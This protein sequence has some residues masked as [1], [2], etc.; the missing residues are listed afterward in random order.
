MNS[1]IEIALWSSHKLY[2]D[3]D[4]HLMGPYDPCAE[5]MRNTGVLKSKQIQDGT[6]RLV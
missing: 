1:W 2:F 4:T 5:E 6:L 3:D